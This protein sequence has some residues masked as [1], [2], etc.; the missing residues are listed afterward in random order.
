VR[1]QLRSKAYLENALAVN[2]LGIRDIFLRD[3]VPA[4]ERYRRLLDAWRNKKEWQEDQSDLLLTICKYYQNA[5]FFST[6]SPDIVHA[7]LNSLKGFDGLPPEK[8][9]TFRETMFHHAFILSLNGGKLNSALRMIPVISSWMDKEE[10]HLSQAQVLPFLCNFMV[11]EFLSGHFAEANKHLNRILQLPYRNVRVDIREFALMLQPFVQYELD[12]T[13]LNEYLTRSRRRHFSK[14]R[15]THDFEMIVIKHIELLLRAGDAAQKKK[16][17]QS[18]ISS[19]EKIS[20]SQS[21]AV[22]LLG[23][24]EIRMWAI[25][26]KNNIPLSAVFVGEVKKAHERIDSDKSR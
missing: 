12:N 18:F 21:R 4:I 11:A 1:Q 13:G 14:N 24:N 6:V 9:R 2:T 19:L 10:K 7:D 25:S 20:E 26:R 17:L 5:C 8:L 3:P 15:K 23:L 16:V 22:P